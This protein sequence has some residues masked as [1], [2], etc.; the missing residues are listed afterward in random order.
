MVPDAESFV[1]RVLFC[2][3]NPSALTRAD[4]LMIA[5]CR[6]ANR[7]FKD[8]PNTVLASPESLST[9]EV[10]ESDSLYTSTVDVRDCFYRIRI[11]EK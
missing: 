3:E 7:G 6:P 5:G 10:S 2:K 8:T 1:Q 9:L 11:P 4:L